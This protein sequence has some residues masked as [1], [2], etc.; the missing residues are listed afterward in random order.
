M[1]LSA[2][3][4]SIKDV[5]KKHSVPLPK[6]ALGKGEQAIC[7]RSVSTC[8]NMR[9]NRSGEITSSPF[10][11]I[12]MCAFFILQGPIIRHLQESE[13]HFLLPMHHR[14]RLSARSSSPLPSL[15]SFII[16]MAVSRLVHHH[17]CRLSARPSSSLPC[18]WR[19]L[20]ACMCVDCSFLSLLS[21]HFARPYIYCTSCFIVE[22]SR[23]AVDQNSLFGPLARRAGQKSIHHVYVRQCSKA[24]NGSRFYSLFGPLARCA[25]QVLRYGVLLIS[26]FNSFV[27]S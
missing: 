9:S 2:L 11:F 19:F 18:L 12:F 16:T 8:N 22:L 27:L 21:F 23:T 20:F 13:T 3:R 15:G 14:C 25:G 1:N 6:T 10:V 4:C 26:Y 24:L 5:L 7:A 17:H